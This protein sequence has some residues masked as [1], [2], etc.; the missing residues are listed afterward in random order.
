ML[1]GLT[2]KNGAGKGEVAEILK[3][4]IKYN[5]FSLSDALRR[6]FIISLSER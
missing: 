5:Y 4:E 2:G 6:E 3:K 1:I